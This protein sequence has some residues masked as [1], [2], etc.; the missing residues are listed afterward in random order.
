MK[1]KLSKKRKILLGGG[2]YFYY[3]GCHNSRFF[4]IERSE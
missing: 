1:D 4:V 3:S 2:S